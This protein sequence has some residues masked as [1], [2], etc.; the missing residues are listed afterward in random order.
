MNDERLRE[1][2]SALRDQAGQDDVAARFTRARVMASVRDSK[3]RRRT[4]VAF[5]VPLAASF[6]VASA[7]GMA[8]G[9]LGRLV[10]RAERVLEL[11]I[12]PPAPSSSARAPTRPRPP[13]RPAPSA[14]TVSEAPPPPPLL[15]A[16]PPPLEAPPPVRTALPEPPRRVAPRPEKK[17][18]PG[19]ELYREAHRAHF[20]EQDYGRALSAW[21]RYL[22]ANPRGR[23]APE[24]RY[25]RA[26]CLLRLGRLD[27]A[28][29]ALTAIAGG[30][31]GGYREREARALLEAMPE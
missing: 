1:F 4:R 12:A 27:E 18:D 14:P 28:R 2:A 22:A 21:D 10:N 9:T 23:L 16:P 11:V 8:S 19:H 3:V 13:A 31:T 5:L 7:W 17:P 25:N 30:A 29:A 20:R 6:V 26:L 15:E 24:A